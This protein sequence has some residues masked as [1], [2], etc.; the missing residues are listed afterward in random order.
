LN[1]KLLKNAIKI[2]IALCLAALV[3]AVNYIVDPAGLYTTDI[4]GSVEEQAVSIML[5]GQNAEGLVNYDE[6]LV[7][8][9]CIY[10]LGDVDTIGLGS[11][12]VALID[13]EMAGEES[14]FNLSVTGAA[15]RDIV[16][17]Y[18]ICH[19]NGLVPERVI[20]ALDPWFI[21]SNYSSGRFEQVLT[22]GYCYALSELMGYDESEIG[23]DPAVSGKYL[24]DGSSTSFFSYPFDMQKELFSLPYFQNSLLILMDG[25]AEADLTATDAFVGE[26]AMLRSDGSYCYPADY[27][28][29]TIDEITSLA[30]S[31]I[32]LYGNGK[33]RITGCED[34][35]PN[36]PYRD[37]FYDFVKYLSESGTDVDLVA[38]PLN[39]ILWDYML[40]HERYAPVVDSMRFY[41][42]MAE[43]LGCD[44][45][46]SFDPHE[47][48]AEAEDFYDGYHYKAEKMEQLMQQLQEVK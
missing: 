24:G 42:D 38:S 12:R 18:G 31:Q 41:R 25:S 44:I 35:D 46:G 37:I 36:D 16:A 20:I 43:D 6:R 17:M 28:S 8:R 14:F 1:K 27:R 5:S 32:N 13:S 11:S 48:G 2:L 7:K 23:Y 33:D 30:E 29:N 15:M 4:S 45:A 34:V 39:P 10:G 3:P 19:M 26:E 22:D 40:Q 47:L 21:N 9:L